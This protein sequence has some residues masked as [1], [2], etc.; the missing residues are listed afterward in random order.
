MKKIVNFSLSKEIWK[1][2]KLFFTLGGL[3]YTFFVITVTAIE[4][5][6]G[7]FGHFLKPLIETNIK[8]PI[9][10]LKSSFKKLFLVLRKIY[11]AA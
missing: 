2:K 5:R 3:S 1:R 4:V 8:T 11:T 9:N 7:I 6:N 10:A